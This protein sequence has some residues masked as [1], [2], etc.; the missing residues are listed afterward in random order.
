MAGKKIAPT[1]KNRKAKNPTTIKLPSQG[2][3]LEEAFSHQ[4]KLALLPAPILEHK[5]H[6]VRRWRFDFAWPHLKVAFEAEGGVSNSRVGRHTSMTGYSGDCEKYA[7]AALDG[8]L[9]IRGTAPMI[10]SGLAL[11]LV[12]RAIAQRLLISGK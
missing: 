8:W 10:R 7:E 4:A 11:S 1:T 2:S 3:K 5:F 9:V 6:T 12:K